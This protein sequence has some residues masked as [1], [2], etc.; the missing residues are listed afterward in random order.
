L[1]PG[2]WKP[3]RRPDHPPQSRAPRRVPLQIGTGP[4]AHAMKALINEARR[5]FQ[6]A[7]PTPAGSARLNCQ[8]PLA[9]LPRPDSERRWHIADW[10]RERIP[11]LRPLAQPAGSARKPKGGTQDYRNTAGAITP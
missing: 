9:P 3:T 11:R 2:S 1:T 4:R 5:R 8:T 6:P 7:T 10:C